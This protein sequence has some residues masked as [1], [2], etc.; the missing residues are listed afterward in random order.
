ME[1][2]RSQFATRLRAA[3]GKR[4]LTQA[5][6]A[7]A[8]GLRRPAISEIEAGRRSVSSQEL[9]LLAEL[10]R[11]PVTYLL[12]GAAAVDEVDLEQAVKIIVERFDPERIILFGSRARGTAGPGSDT[13][14]LVVVDA[15]GSKRQ[16]AVEIGVALHGI[17][18][19]KD[20]VVTTPAAFEWRRHVV[21]TLE[22]PAAREGTLLYERR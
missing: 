17:R 8:L 15:P 19:A 21:G 20:I 3:R 5:E 14:L 6:V 4:G 2:T 1:A 7:V 18:G 22:R 13:D 11:V 16:K 9:S 10:Y 12:D